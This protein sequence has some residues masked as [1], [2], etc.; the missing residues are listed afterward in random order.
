MPFHKDL[1]GADLHESKIPAY[2]STGT[3][4][5]NSPGKIIKEGTN[6]SLNVESTTKS[7]VVSV[8]KPLPTGTVIGDT[9][10]Q[11]LQNKNLVDSTTR[12]VNAIDNT[13]KLE[14]S[15]SGNT[16]VTGILATSFTTAKT[17]S[18][19]DI[20]D[21]LVA[22]STGD[23]L[24]NKTLTSGT[25]DIAANKLRG[26]SIIEIS[27]LSTP[28]GGDGLIYNSTLGKAQWSPA[29][30][31]SGGSGVSVRGGSTTGSSPDLTIPDTLIS[32][33]E[34]R[35]AK[36]T[37]AASN[38]TTLTFLGAVTVQGLWIQT[39]GNNST[40]LYLQ[41]P[42]TFPTAS[43]VVSINNND[44]SS[45]DG[46][47]YAIV[48]LPSGGAGGTIWA[49]DKFTATAGQT[50]FILSQFP[51]QPSGIFAYGNGLY[52]NNTEYTISGSGNIITFNFG[53]ALGTV[54]VIRYLVA[55]SI[56]WKEDVFTISV[57]TSPTTD[58]TLSSTPIQN[59]AAQLYVNGAYRIYG[60]SYDYTISGNV[61]TVNGLT[62]TD[63]VAVKYQYT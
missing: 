7:V 6:I 1:I 59:T 30:G 10:T 4:I 41:S 45:I 46:V 16:G 23:V 62:I 20:T 61:A 57:P 49:E 48:T 35:T 2:N 55:V 9:D 53:W 40:N 44:T 39:V 58:L 11:T 26:A 25:N 27:S 12:I 50:V 17:L 19:P 60:P 34:L 15:V 63:V 5:L 42:Q 37:F 47:V 51:S 14:F 32:N 54:V 36:V 28:A 31:S 21:S 56:N 24:T 18:L 3:E 52:R 29:S 33:T 43:N 13:K 22:R 38:T 8:S